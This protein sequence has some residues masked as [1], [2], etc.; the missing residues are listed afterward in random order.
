MYSPILTMTNSVSQSLED[1][2]AAGLSTAMGF[3]AISMLIGIAFLLA[4]AALITWVVKKVWYAGR[5]RERKRAK[6]Q[7]QWYGQQDRAEWE[8]F[9]RYGTTSNADFKQNYKKTTHNTK[10]SPTGWIWD[11]EKGLWTPPDYLIKENR[12]R[13]KWD[14][15]KRIWKENTKQ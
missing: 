14:E 7:R 5:N 4:L 10:I 1:A 3:I 13:W 15:N 2:V 11:E 9:R 12:Q 8:E 6:K